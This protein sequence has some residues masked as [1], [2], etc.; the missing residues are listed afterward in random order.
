MR[1]RRTL[2]GITTSLC[3][4]G[5]SA[6]A[7]ADP[8]LPDGR[9]YEMVTPA[10]NQD[11]DVYV[12]W[13]TSGLTLV[14]TVRRRRCRF[15]MAVGGEAVVYV[16]DA[17]TGGDGE[18][19]RGLGD[20]YLARRGAAGGWKQKAIQPPARRRAQFQGFSSD[21][22]TGV[23]ASGSFSERQLP[24]LKANAPGEDTRCFMPAIT[25]L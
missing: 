20:Q 10:E 5:I 16:D 19:G 25:V 3:V 8:A 13:A 9:V 15:Q 2:L 18:N 7:L 17:T 11:A 24:P 6:S 14:R 1:I 12:P 4:L 23:L 21:L 22:T